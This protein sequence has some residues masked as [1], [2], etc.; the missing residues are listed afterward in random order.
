MT[1]F[2]KVLQGLMRPKGQVTNVPTCIQKE[3]LLPECV[4]IPSE[5]G[6]ATI[7]CRNPT[8]GEV[9]RTRFILL[10]D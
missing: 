4:A 6:T 5:P 1:S 9:F 10:A 3:E 8:T 7:E 2:M